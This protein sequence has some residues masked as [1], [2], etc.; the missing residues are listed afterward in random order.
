MCMSEFTAFA[1]IDIAESLQ[2]SRDNNKEKSWYVEGYATTEDLDL[3]EDILLAEGMNIDHLIADGFINYEHN[4]GLG[5]IVGVPTKNCVVDSTGLYLEGKL[6]KENVYAQEIWSLAE[7]VHKSQVDR[8]LGFSIEGLALE[9]DPHDPRRITKS[10][11]TNVAVTTRPVN[12]NAT[13]KAFM[14]S[15]TTGYA[16]T[17]EEMV[18]GASL[19]PENLARDLHSVA[20][21]YSKFANKT[22][23]NAVWSQVG[24]FLDTADRTTPEV[25]VLFLQ[26]TE[27]LSRDDAMETVRKSFNA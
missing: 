7:N 13:W 10:I 1:T 14:K 25:A 3:E 18:D 12:P 2:K 9:R 5:H 16:T 20:Q 4:S 17:P 6:F 26:I 15:L 11:I 23:F 21:T 27:G 19:R 8:T 22:E 24:E